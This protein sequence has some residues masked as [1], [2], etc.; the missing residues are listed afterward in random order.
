LIYR[1]TGIF[2]AFL[3]VG[4]LRITASLL[5]VLRWWLEIKEKNKTPQVGKINIGK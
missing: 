1:H 3:V 2:A 4:I 5:Y